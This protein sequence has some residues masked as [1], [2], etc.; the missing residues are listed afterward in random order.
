MKLSKFVFALDMF[1]FGVFR[2]CSALTDLLIFH[3]ATYTSS[4]AFCS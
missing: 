2:L 3:L 4:G 1:M